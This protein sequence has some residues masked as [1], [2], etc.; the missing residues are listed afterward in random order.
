MTFSQR[1]ELLEWLEQISEQS[2]R[3]GEIIRRV[4]SFVR[5]TPAQTQAVDINQVVHECAR[6]LQVSLRHQD[7]ALQL[8]LSPSLSDVV[9]DPVQIQQVLINLLSNAIDAMGPLPRAERQITV[10]SSQNETGDIDVSVGD[11]G[12]GD[13]E[14]ELERLFEPFFTTKA[15]GMGMGLAISRSIIEAHRGRLWAERNPDT[16]LTFRFTVPIHSQELDHEP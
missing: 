11:L 2:Q 5:K 8:E 1:T 14:D 16:G 10:R 7:V 13:S 12:R 9:V 4:Y 3:A 15:D 6:L